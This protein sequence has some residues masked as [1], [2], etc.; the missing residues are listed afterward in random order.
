MIMA[1]HV[2]GD[3]AN[4]NCKGLQNHTDLDAILAENYT[5]PKYKSIN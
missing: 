3:A 4:V 5:A 1:V 2:H